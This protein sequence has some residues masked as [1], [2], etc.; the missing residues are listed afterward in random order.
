M[1]D[2]P[3]DK[4]LSELLGGGES[5]SGAGLDVGYYFHLLLRYIWLF[6]AIV[7]I[8]AAIGAYMALRQPQR[9]TATAVI[10]V[11]Q[12]EQ[13][14]L[15]TEETV[16]LESPDY[17][18]TIVATLT[19]DS[20]LVRVAKAANLIN[21][22]EF[23]EPRP[24][25]Y[26]D[27]E[28]ADRMRMMVSATVR[29]LTRLIDVQ[30]TDTNA[31][32]AQLIAETM[33]KEFMRQAVEQRVAAAQVANDFLRD[34]AEKLKAKLEA[35]E[36]K[37]QKYK[38]EQ[39]AVSLQEDQNI[40]V[41]KL[42]E[43]NAQVGEAR[44]QRIKLESAME[45]LKKLPATDTD[46]MLQIPS[47]SAIEQ[48]QALRAQ[49]V[50]AEA[51]LAAT[52]KR[53]LPQHPQTIQATTQLEQ[54]RSALADTLR[55]AG[56]VLNTQYQAAV[57]SENKL[58]EALKEQEQVALELNKIAIPYNVLQREVDSDRAMYDAVN[59]RLRETNVSLGVEATPFRI[60]QEPLAA[61]P[62][63]RPLLKWLGL[64]L[65]LGLALG[66]GTIFG[67]DMLD[68][69][70]RYV[71][72]AESF[73][74][75]P[76]LAV[77][78]ELG[79]QRGDKIPSV[80]PDA[81]QSQQA[82]AFRSMRTTLSLLGDEAH[83]RSFLVT[84]AIPGEGKTFC[85]YNAAVAFAAEGQKTIFV[86]ADLR[87]PAVHKIFSDSEG[88]RR[89]TGLSDYLAGDVEIDGIIMAG[90]QENLSVICAGGKTS[91]PGELLGADNF[92]TLM[93]TLTER[94][95]RIIIDS[96]PVNAV[97]DTLRITPLANYV[98]LVVRAA[99]T[100]KKALAR[101]KKLI[102]NAKGKL[103][104]FIL[105]RVHLGRDSAYYFY[106]YAYGSSDAKA[107]RGS[108]KSSAGGRA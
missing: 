44:N 47:V 88:A 106:H 67:L 23:F 54:L 107:S 8:C 58:N 13:R 89:H 94:F 73:L 29:R 91:N 12:Q 87:M 81:S 14:V 78:S 103:A 11:E 66:A 82:E 104:G 108:K 18:S 49:I 76:V 100:P 52:Q 20:F 101:A 50:T 62:V 51:N 74:K 16:R 90:P 70:L 5:S 57:D 19:G 75:L 21:D 105:N 53:Y 42:K 102:E 68:S 32:R 37:L 4:Q 69:S 61:K 97:S 10:Q 22:P 35:S 2:I 63:P 55:N 98:C 95:D 86:D 92:A 1:A 3:S 96:A 72:Q 17:L 38:E 77:V 26:S 28:I 84:S 56:N 79:G 33:V 71:D 60:V 36:E 64:G 43:L 31:E 65:F 34:E 7:L 85:A 6:L 27:A 30:A 93:K 59:A 25:P 24:E 80:F 9:Y 40:T 48:V 15:R 39:N 83:R 41:Q 46:Q 45:L 99:K